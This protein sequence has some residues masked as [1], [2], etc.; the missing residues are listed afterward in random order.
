MKNILITGCSKGIGYDTVKDF[1]Q[2][3]DLNIFVISRNIEGL[4]M[5]KKEC[6]TINKKSNI[7]II[8]QDLSDLSSISKS[9][10]YI[11]EN[12]NVKFDGLIHNAGFLVNKSFAK[13][14]LKELEYSFKVNSLAPFILTQKLL[15]SFR[16]DA[17]IIFISSMG[18]VQGSKKFPGLSAYSTSKSTLITLT[19]CLTEEFNMTDL[20]FNCLALG[21]V[22]TEMLS[23]AFP[24]YKAPLGSDQM[25]KFIV[26]FYFEGQK[27]FKGQILPVS[28]T[29]P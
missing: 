22:Q 15:S 1:V 26:D 17:H 6:K 10:E 28:L 7:Y 20:T 8:S 13:I 27:Y 19:Q 9:V 12:F 21:A 5:L 29:T 16:K 24:G 18:G 14:S 3:T 4:E 11:Q 25:A 2:K 23:N